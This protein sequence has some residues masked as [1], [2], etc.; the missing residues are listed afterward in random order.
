MIFHDYNPVTIERFVQQT[1]LTFSFSVVSVDQSNSRFGN[2][3]EDYVFHLKLKTK[4]NGG[5][6]MTFSL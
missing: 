5:N 6:S 2:V 4:Q 1:K 3:F